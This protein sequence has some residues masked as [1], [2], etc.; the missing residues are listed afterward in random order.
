MAV[1]VVVVRA[2]AWACR[3]GEQDMSDRL[4]QLHMLEDAL[5]YNSDL[6]LGS[7]LPVTGKGY[8]QDEISQHPAHT[9]VGLAH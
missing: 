9:Q 8:G 2:C 5:G 6:G 1:S 3:R 4:L 7:C